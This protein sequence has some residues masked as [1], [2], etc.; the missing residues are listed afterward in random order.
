MKK[1]PTHNSN[2]FEARNKIKKLF[3]M[4]FAVLLEPSLKSSFM[5]SVFFYAPKTT[6]FIK[7]VSFARFPLEILVL[8][9]DCINHSINIHKTIYTASIHQDYYI[10]GFGLLLDPIV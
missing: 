7:K 6:K 3:C 10:H 8:L 2:N 1:C 5:S 4:S 9:I